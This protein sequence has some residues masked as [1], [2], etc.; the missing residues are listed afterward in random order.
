MEA[1]YVDMRMTVDKKIKELTGDTRLSDALA[2]DPSV[3]DYI[4][5]LNPHDFERLR[6][7]LLRKVMPPRITLRR[8]AAIAGISECELVSKI[9]ELS[10]VPFRAPAENEPLKAVPVSASEQPAWMKDLDLEKILW[11]DVTPIDSEFGDPMPPIN[12]AVNGSKPG[13]VVG[14]KHKWEPQPLFD[15][16]QMRGFQFWTHQEGPDLW[17]IFVYRPSDS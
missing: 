10:G 1:L 16:W 4:V 15:I 6:T 3:L 12:I 14:I 17:H 5:S 13:D 8:V 2:A 9:S 11:V 7:P